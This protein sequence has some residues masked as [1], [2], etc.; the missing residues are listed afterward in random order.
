MTGSYWFRWTGKRFRFLGIW[1]RLTGKRFRFWFFDNRNVVPLY[2]NMV[3]V[4]MN[5]QP[6]S[7]S[8]ADLAFDD[9][10]GLDETLNLIPDAPVRLLGFLR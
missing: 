2:R 3:P 5:R 8:P 10:A 1:F 4:I 6:V 7:I 9:M